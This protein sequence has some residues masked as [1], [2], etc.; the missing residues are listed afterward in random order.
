MWMKID[1]LIHFYTMSSLLSQ[2]S[3]IDIIRVALQLALA[4]GLYLIGLLGDSYYGV[5]EALPALW[6][7]YDSLFEL[8]DYTR[9][10]LFFAPIFLML[11]GLMAERKRLL[12]K[13]QAIAGFAVSLL[14]MS[15]K[16]M[17]LRKSGFPRHDSMYVFLPPC[18]FFLFQFALHFRVRKVRSLRT[19][20]LLIYLVHPMMIVA[21]RAVARWMRLQSL[22]IGNSLIHFAAACAGN[23][24][25]S[26]AAAALWT[27]FGEKQRHRAE[28]ERA[29]IEIN[30]AHLSH[31]AAVLQAAMPKG[32]AL[33][34][35]VKAEAYGHGAC[36]VAAH[37]ERNGVGAF[38][39]ATINE[40]IRLRRCGIRGEILILGFTDV[41]RVRE[42]RK[43]RLTQTLIDF[44]YA[45]RLNSQ[46][47]PVRVNIGIDSGMHRLG[48]SD[49]DFEHVRRVFGM[50]NLKVNG[51]FTHLCCC[52]SLRPEDVAFTNGQ[53]QRFS[54]LIGRA[55]AERDFRSEAAHSE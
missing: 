5:V 3:L 47:V 44:D 32:C 42:L 43:Y 51:M 13:A 24:L 20:S 35:V 31:N 45:E 54:A 55:E 8:F 39:V 21:V 25:F 33:M 50:K 52:E 30:L 34:A 22:L 14:L 9:N 18:A 17:L 29:Y 4:S 10:G 15:A 49:G 7:A 46:G 2:N 36:A 40:A 26:F 6:R 19:A 1:L 23:I 41:H 48:L 16:A 28:T 53:I 12:P 37:L 38:A 11:G 27:R